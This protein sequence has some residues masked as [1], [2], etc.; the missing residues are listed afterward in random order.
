MKTRCLQRVFLCVLVADALDQDGQGQRSARQLMK[1]PPE[2]GFC[3][4]A[5]SNSA[6]RKP[7]KASTRSR[8]TP[9]SAELSAT[10][11]S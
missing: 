3:M 9:T 5:Q 2:G 4:Q 7:S 11:E 10:S 8:L 1:K 6:Q